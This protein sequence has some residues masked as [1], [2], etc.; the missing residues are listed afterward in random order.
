MSF[1]F[2]IQNFQSIADHTIEVK[3]FTTI[4]GP[5]N[6]G[7]SAIIRALRAWAYNELHPSDIRDTNNPAKECILTGSW[8]EGNHLNV[9]SVE[10]KKS[11]KLNLYTVTFMDGTE[12]SYPKI[13]TDTPDELKQLGFLLLETEREDTFNLNFQSQLDNLFLVTEQPTMLTSFFNKIFDIAK[14]ERALR[15]INSDTIQQ[16]RQYDDLSLKSLHKRNE[17]DEQVKLQEANQE[18]LDRLAAF[19]TSIKQH[20]AILALYE[21]GETALLQYATEAAQLATLRA[22]VVTLQARQI[23]LQQLTASLLRFQRLTALQAQ[24]QRTQTQLQTAQQLKA[25]HATAATLAT[26][27][28]QTLAKLQRQTA[29]G[30]TLRTATYQSVQTQR[31]LALFN[32]AHTATTQIVG[33][34][35]KLAQASL[36]TARLRTLETQ[37]QM[38]TQQVTTI[39]AGAG[40]AARLQTTLARFQ[41]L[42]ATKLQIGTHT[43]SLDRLGQTAQDHASTLGLI[44]QYDTFI[45]PYIG[46]CPVCHQPLDA[47]AH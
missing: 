38:A 26:R 40:L 16:Q 18:Q 7:K 34:L 37:R 43:Q 2:R 41:R 11:S 27:L 20:E 13:G 4:V 32:T 19:V 28:R 44:A 10:F 22:T 35:R 24:L 30:S 9:R 29:L 17:L 3:G 8:P 33:S 5:S 42:T 45:K 36:L 23:Q 47:H 12:K 1:R 25:T 46:T 14:Y 31:D 6:L 39:R 15:G 21:R